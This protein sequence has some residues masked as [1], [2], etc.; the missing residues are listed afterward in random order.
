MAKFVYEEL[1]ISEAAAIHDGDPYTQGLA[2]AFADAF[3]NLAVLS[4]DSPA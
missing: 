4:R 1:E 3:G 2:Q